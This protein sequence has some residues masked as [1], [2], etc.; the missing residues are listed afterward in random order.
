GI[1]N[2]GV[3]FR[4]VFSLGEYVQVWTSLGVSDEWWGIELHRLLD[5]G[6]LKAQRNDPRII[7]GTTRFLAAPLALSDDSP[8]PSFYFPLPLWSETDP[9]IQANSPVDTRTLSTLVVVPLDPK[10]VPSVLEAIE[11]LRRTHLQ[12]VGLRPARRNVVV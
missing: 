11:E 6:R 2:K 1:G 8:R 10:A 3:G 5:R 7:A 9:M 12:F 4:S